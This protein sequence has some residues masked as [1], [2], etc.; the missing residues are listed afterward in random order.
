MNKGVSF[1]PLEVT[2]QDLD[3]RCALSA[4]ELRSG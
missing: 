2:V 3:L 1:Q 4:N